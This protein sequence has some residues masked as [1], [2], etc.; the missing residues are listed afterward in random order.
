M[1]AGLG[2]GSLTLTLLEDI[3]DMELYRKLKD[4]RQ[5]TEPLTDFLA[6]AGCFRHLTS[7]V[8]KDKLLEDVLMFQVAQ[9]LRGD[10]IC[11]S[12]NLSCAVVCTQCE[13]SMNRAACETRPVTVLNAHTVVLY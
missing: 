13:S 3:A 1:H 2:L 8:D 6:T 7:L 9:R 4:L 5:L 12:V 10:Q 11:K